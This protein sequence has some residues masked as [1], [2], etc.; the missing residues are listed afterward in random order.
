M[1]CC[2]HYFQQSIGSFTLETGYREATEACRALIIQPLAHLHGVLV[3]GYVCKLFA[4]E[5]WLVCTE[6]WPADRHIRTEGWSRKALVCKP[7]G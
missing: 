5:C 3:H 1:P 4:D 7:S 2:I 6:G